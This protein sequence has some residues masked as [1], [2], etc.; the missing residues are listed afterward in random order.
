MINQ[1]SPTTTVMR[2]AVTVLKSLG[3]VP[4]DRTI[5]DSLEKAIA[6]ATMMGASVSKVEKQKIKKDLESRFFTT[7]GQGTILEDRLNHE[8]W[9]DDAKGK[10]EWKFWKRYERYLEET[11]HWAFQSIVRLD[12]ITDSILERLESPERDGRWSRR[13]MVVGQ[14]QSGKTANYTGLICKAADA[15]YRLIIVL[16][17][18]HNSLRSQTQLRLDEGFLGRDTKDNLKFDSVSKRIGAGLISGNARLVAHALTSNQDLGDFNQKSAR[19]SNVSIGSKEPILL[20]VKKNKSVLTNLVKWIMNS[21][22]TDEEEG[23]GKR[24][25]TDIPVLVIDDEADNA[26]VNTAPIYDG[27]NNIDSDLDPSAINKLIRQLLNTFHKSAYVGYTATPFANIF[28][29]PRIDSPQFG[30]DLFPRSFIINLKA[31]SSYVGPVQVFGLDSDVETVSEMPIIRTIDDYETWIP[32]GHK[33]DFHPGE[34]PQSLK[35]AIQSFV[36]ICAARLERGQRNTHNSML[37]HVSRFTSIQSIVKDQ[38]S[39][40]LKSLQRI[41]EFG[42]G[43]S[44]ASPLEEMRLLW[45]SDFDS[46]TRLMAQSQNVSWQTLK[47]YLHEAAAKIKLKEINGTAKDILEYREN[48]NGLSVIAIGGEKLSRGLTLEGLSVSYF[49]RAAKMYDTLMQMGRWFG[50]RPGYSDLCRLY[51][52][53]ELISWYKFITVASEELRNEFDAMEAIGATPEEFGLKVM[54]HPGG[55]HITSV[56]KMKSGVDMELSFAGS[57]SETVVFYK[58]DVV[59][60]QNLD[61]TDMFLRR[62]GNAYRPMVKKS[63]NYVWDNTDTDLILDFISKYKVHPSSRA[64]NIELLTKYIQARQNDGELSRWTVAV[65]TKTSDEKFN[66]GGLDIG[67]TLRNEDNKSELGEYALPKRHIL[68]PLDEAIDLSD[69]EFRIALSKTNEDRIRL[70]KPET[71]TPGGPY[72]RGQRP[73]ERGLLLLYIL[74]PKGMNPKTYMRPVPGFVFS[75]PKSNHSNRIS[76]KVNNVFYEQEFGS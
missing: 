48:S 17:G 28:I 3:G 53:R 44:A 58:D 63:D 27:D 6:M 9:L 37:V 47:P 39:L 54:T 50:Y 16:S 32:D 2:L 76:Y 34:L 66:L 65:I 46:T 51:T 57:I 26:S 23:T 49:L 20:V 73:P 31:P 1:D 40:Y 71:K 36:L 8:P 68:S 62:L 72:I 43:N 41:I 10:K 25:I 13:G 33:K 18:L 45:E 7:V 5:D 56:N 67:L 70:R 64:A 42:A 55:L 12:E 61:V 75:F 59:N 30:E 11:D 29:H 74:D 38:V 69:E 24:V 22:F 15:G 4:D 35:V 14:V 52:S 60:K 21:D 19:T